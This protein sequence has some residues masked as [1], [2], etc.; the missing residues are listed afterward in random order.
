MR[1]MKDVGRAEE[2]DRFGKAKE[3]CSIRA[4]AQI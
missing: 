4:R 2:D 3:L 1:G